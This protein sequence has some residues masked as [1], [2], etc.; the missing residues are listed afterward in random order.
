MDYLKLKDQ[1]VTVWE[2]AVRAKVKQMP[3][4]MKR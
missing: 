2:Q 4:V 1:Q 3:A